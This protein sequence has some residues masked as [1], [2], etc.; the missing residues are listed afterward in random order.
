MWTEGKNEEKRTRKEEERVRRELKE[1]TRREKV[2]EREKR[3]I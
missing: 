1:R 3:E 2:I